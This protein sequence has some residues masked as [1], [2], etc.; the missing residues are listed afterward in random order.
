[1]NFMFFLICVGFTTSAVK[2]NRYEQRLRRKY[3][4]N[5]EPNE[6]SYDGMGLVKLLSISLV[7]GLV[8]GALGLGGGSIYNP[9]L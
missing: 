4:V 3:S 1:M 8:S 9:C 7:G 5:Y 6:V 2:I